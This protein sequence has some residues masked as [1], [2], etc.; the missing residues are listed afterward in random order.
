LLD[1]CR[2]DYWSCCRELESRKNGESSFQ[3]IGAFCVSK[4]V[5]KCISASK[6]FPLIFIKK[7]NWDVTHANFVALVSQLL[8]VSQDSNLKL[9]HV[10]ETPVLDSFQ[11]GRAVQD[12]RD[13]RIADIF[14]DCIFRGE[15]FCAVGRGADGD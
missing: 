1:H 13:A 14:F 3:D 5:F 10:L 8:N 2:G 6:F 15:Q 9:V 7:V 12:E 4:T 11:D